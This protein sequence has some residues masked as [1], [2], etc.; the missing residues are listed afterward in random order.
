MESLGALANQVE[1]IILNKTVFNNLT[2]L[3]FASIEQ[4]PTLLE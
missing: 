1:L 4:L 3:L 2:C